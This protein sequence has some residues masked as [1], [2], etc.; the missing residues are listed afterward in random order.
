MSS[1]LEPLRKT[2]E[3]E[4]GKPQENENNSSAREKDD[5]YE[6]CLVTVLSIVISVAPLCCTALFA[7][8][9]GTTFW[10]HIIGR[11]DILFTILTL[12]VTVVCEIGF[13]NVKKN[14]LLK[15]IIASLILGVFWLTTIYGYYQFPTNGSLGYVYKKHIIGISALAISVLSVLS[16]LVANN[17]KRKIEK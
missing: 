6:F 1:V 7:N 5:F 10:D 4:T 12:T 3:N 8:V 11:P 15:A 14:R 17:A 16:M 13:L 2:Q 9:E